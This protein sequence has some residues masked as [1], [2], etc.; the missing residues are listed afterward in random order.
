MQAILSAEDKRFFQHS[1]LDTLRIAKATYVDL[2]AR[3][4]QQG[5][6]TI[7]MQLARNLSLRRNKSWKRKMEEVMITVHLEHKL[8][9]NQIFEKYSNL[10]YLGGDGA[11]GINGVGEAA[12]AYFNKDVRQ[13][14]LPEAAT[15]AGLIQRPVY[16]N[17]FRYPNRALDRRNVVLKRMLQ[18]KYITGEQYA[19]ATAATLGL[20]G[21]TTELSESQY[22]VDAAAKEAARGLTQSREKR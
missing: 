9:K 3:R 21:G 20:H 19:E 13:L 4:K 16:F 8:S 6:S 11:F 22:F 7:T 12:E 14:N 5:A 1:G 17:P 10:V 15:I 18:N 2:K